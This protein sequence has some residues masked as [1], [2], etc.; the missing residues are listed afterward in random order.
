M[1]DQI[2]TGRIYLS[3]TLTVEEREK[4][5][6]F[7]TQSAGDNRIWINIGGQIKNPDAKYELSRTNLDTDCSQENCLTFEITDNINTDEADR[8]LGGIGYSEDGGIS[9]W[10]TSGMPDVEAFMICI[11]SSETIQRVQLSFVPAHGYP[12][13]YYTIVHDIR[14]NEICKTMMRCICGGAVPDSQLNI[15]K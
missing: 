4:L 3:H 6:S 15:I 7:L 1:A 14:A 11:M 8:I 9:D 5:I 12:P 2:I 10:G 13:K